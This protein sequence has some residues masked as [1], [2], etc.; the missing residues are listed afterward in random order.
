MK[1]NNLIEDAIFEMCDYFHDRF[2]TDDRKDVEDTLKKLIE[3][4]Q[5]DAYERAAQHLIDIEM[6]HAEAY[7]TEIRK[8]KEEGEEDES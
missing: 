3:K 6:D 7:A 1:T 2:D 8:L 4:A 5:A